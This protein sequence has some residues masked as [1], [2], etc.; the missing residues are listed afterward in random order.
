MNRKPDTPGRRISLI[1]LAAGRSQR[2]GS[3]HKL[4][5]PLNDKTVLE[6]LL[7]TLTDVG[8]HEIIVVTGSRRE[9]VE[10]LLENYPARAA[11]N[12]SFQEG[13][14]ASI[15]TG[16]HAA[17]DGSHAYMFCLA[18][19]PRIQPG[20]LRVLIDAFAAGPAGAIVRPICKGR[21]GNPVTLDRRYRLA[22]LQLRGDS[23]AR[24][25][26]NDHRQS[27][28]DVPVADRGVLEDFDTLEDYRNFGG[29]GNHV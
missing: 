9:K 22:L 17:D 5:L 8:G 11:F 24:T 1:V 6:K 23:G 13:I 10:R 26:C 16:V 4:L 18:D 27:V 12:P 14:A 29:D 3:R 25:I 15:R 21:P 7:D 2:M 28:I 20:T 19:M